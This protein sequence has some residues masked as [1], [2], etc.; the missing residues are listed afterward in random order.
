[1]KKTEI[2]NGILHLSSKDILLATIIKKAGKCN[3]KPHTEYYNSLLDAIIGQ[4]LS[5]KAAESIIRKF[6]GF[7]GGYPQPHVVL[8]TED[9]ILRSLGLSNAKVRYVKD[10]SEKVKDGSVILGK[11]GKKTDEEIIEEL[12]K[13]KGIG[14]WTAHMFLIFTLGRP[15]VLPTLDLGIRKAIMQTYRL[16]TMPDDA[17][18]KKI[19]KKRGWEPYCTLASWYLWKS[20]EFK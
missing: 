9:S 19:A 12:T 3:L 4:Q 18:I 15:N 14:V 16:K 1:M 8:E 6:T 11:F 5:M 10:L 7:F 13:V 2:E 17:S 20:L